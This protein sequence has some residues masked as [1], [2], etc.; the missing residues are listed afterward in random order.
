MNLT[1]PHQ[2]LVR[3]TLSLAAPNRVLRFRLPGWTPGSYLIRDYVRHLERLEVWQGGQVL[4]LRQLAP[5]AWEVEPSGHQPIE[6]RTETL[7]TDLSVRT[8]HLNGQHGFLALA[9]LAL[10]VEGERWNPH[11]LRLELPEGW[12]A[13]VP[14]PRE[15][16]GSWIAA[17]FDALVDAPVEAG[18]HR[19]HRFEVHGVPHRWV[20]WETG[21]PLLE[22]HSEL[23]E[24]VAAICRRCCLFM[25][26]P[27]PAADNYL[28]VLHLLDEG[29]GGLEHDASTVLQFGRK[30]LGRPDG[31]RKLLQLVGHEYLHQ[32]NVRRLRPAELTPIDYHQSVVVPSLWFAEG[33]TSY[34]DQLLPFAA[35]LSDEAAALEDLG[36]DFSR[37]LLTPG[38]RVQSLR[39]SSEQAWVKLYKRDASSDDNQISYYLKGALLALVL[40]LHL[41]RAGSA[42]FVVVRDLWRRLGRVGRGYREADLIAAF[43][44]RS[45][46]LEA[47]LP[48]WLGSTEDPPFAAYLADMGLELVAEPASHPESGIV[49]QIDPHQVLVVRKLPRHGPGERSGLELGDELLAL[50]GVRLR[51][52]EDLPPLLRKDRGQRLLLARRGQVME[53]AFTSSAPAIERWTL[54]IDP[55]APADAEERRRRWLALEPEPARLPDPETVRC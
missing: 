35:G 18:P 21:R 40:D 13:F 1:A 24:Q 46:D 11:R 9:A 19:E 39:Q 17:D 37:Y 23:L 2:P 33:I 22:L 8:C 20:T 47:L 14:L 16:D 12:E 55:Q 45:S 50:D 48:A 42:L 53:L 7:A 36:A 54:R 10:E 31:L 32:W 29:Y 34:V 44:R 49:C 30:A 38:R 51:Q 41:R 27:A 28:F 52:A 5:A 3:A 15:A 26:E 4:P 43:A 6:I 25:G